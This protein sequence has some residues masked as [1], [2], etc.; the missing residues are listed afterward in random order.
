[1][2]KLI[3]TL[4]ISSLFLSAPSLSKPSLDGALLAQIGPSLSHPWGMDFITTDTLLVSLRAG[5]L[6]TINITTGRTQP[7][8]GLPKIGAYG[9]GGLLDILVH[10]ADKNVADKNVADSSAPK[11]VFYCYSKPKPRG[12]ATAIDSALFSDNQL[13]QRQ[14][15]FTSNHVSSAGQHF[16]CRLAWRDGVLFASLGD[17]G[18]RHSAQDPS[19]HSGSIIA[20]PVDAPATKTPDTRAIPSGWLPELYSIGHRNPQGLALDPETGALYAHEHGPQGGDEINLIQ[21]GGNYGWPRYTHGKEYGGGVIGPLSGLDALDPLWVW[22]PSIAP[23]GLA[24]YQ[25]T[26]F[27][28]LGQHLL[29][30]SLKFQSLYA[31]AKDG[32]GGFSSEHILL[33]GAIGRIRDVAVAPDGS[34]LLLVDAADGGLYRLSHPQ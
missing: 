16:G 20:L 17:R 13:T 26:M 23:S 31:V 3:L 11:R 2:K 29:I 34:I 5:T 1:M 28:S 22:T 25:G 15:I 30:G 12:F 21:P 32:Q 18:D 14:T 4:C 24:F 9:Q 27:P 33:K 8:S 7:V 19:D 6:S 10:P